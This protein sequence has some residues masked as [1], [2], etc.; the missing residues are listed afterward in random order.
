MASYALVGSFAALVAVLLLASP[1]TAKLTTLYYQK[2]CPNVEKIVSDVVTTKQISTPTTAAASLRLFFHDC[3]VGGCDASVLVSSNA[4]NRAERDADDN[5]SL[6]GDGFDAI[7]RAK[8]A[9]ELQCPGVV[10]CADVLALATRELVL[11]LG[12]P[13]YR[14][15]LG[16]KDALTST[17]EYGPL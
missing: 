13:F 16:R 9:L 14:V 8:I 4:F 11:M 1:A 3:F 10:S 2:T 15:R 17:T 6:P 7:V 12:G 5:V